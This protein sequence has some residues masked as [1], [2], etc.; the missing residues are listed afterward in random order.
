[1]TGAP[2]RTVGLRGAADVLNVSWSSTAVRDRQPYTAPMAS[3]GNA[4][5]VG[6]GVRPRIELVV[7]L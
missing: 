5:N 2:S 4:W 7:R 3:S 1:V 6:F